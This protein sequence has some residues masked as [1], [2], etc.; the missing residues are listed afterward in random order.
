MREHI[1]TLATAVALACGLVAP[2]QANQEK[3]KSVEQTLSDANKEGRIW[4]SFAL[5]RH[6]DA[7][8]FDIDVNG[9]TATLGGTVT[10]PIDKELAE[11]VALSVS[12]VKD[13]VN[14]I[15]VDAS[16][17]P[18]PR[19]HSERSVAQM[20]EDAT[21]TAR[22]KSKLL[23]SEHTEGMAIDVDTKNNVVTLNGKVDTNASKDLAERYAANTSGVRKV[24]NALVVGGE[25]VARKEPASDQPLSD[26]WI[27]TKV[28]SS[29]LFSR[30]LMDDD[31]DVNT[32]N[33]VVTLT[34]AVE[35]A[36]ERSLAIEIADNI[37]G[38]KRVDASHLS[39][40][41]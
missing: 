11:Q 1:L 25:A 10:E 18:K 12:G 24:V 9:D 14:N 31:I 19:T 28:R 7:F 16:Y 26:A 29:L 40:R 22:V 27:T 17:Q 37:R 38:T 20:T 34:G 13:V 33:G 15:K 8:D 2:T 3:G 5:N 21:I 39:T 4:A 41:R 32:S 6:L 23:W 36:K 35:G 30:P